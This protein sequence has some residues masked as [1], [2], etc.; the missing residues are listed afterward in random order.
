MMRAV[1][2]SNPHSAIR[3]RHSRTL[4]AGGSDLAPRRRDY[5][6][7]QT[8]ISLLKTA[9]QGWR[10]HCAFQG[11]V[12]VQASSTMPVRI[13]A[14]APVLF[15][16]KFARVEGTRLC[17]M[18]TRLSCCRNRAEGVSRL[19]TVRFILALI[20][21]ASPAAGARGQSA[22][23][24]A[25]Q[26]P[27]APTNIASPT[28]TTGA[29]AVTLGEDVLPKITEQPAFIQ[30]GV[31]VETLDGRVV[32][33]QAACRRRARLVRLARRTARRRRVAHHAERRRH[34]SGL[35]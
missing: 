7:S 18:M 23:P 2:S 12:V 20:I 32:R 33:E 24:A 11:A 8:A 29:S 30:Q 9:L 10:L 34:G 25:S 17:V 3:N 14:F 15:P 1:L 4:A 21:L 28:P 26:L 27:S 6:Q 31:L 5:T 22:R 19:K 35:R 16:R 13:Q